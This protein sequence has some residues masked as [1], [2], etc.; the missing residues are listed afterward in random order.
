MPDRVGDSV[1]VKV[2]VGVA[3][4][5]SVTVS[6]D[7]GDSVAV[8]LSDTLPL[9]LQEAE[10]DIVGDTDIEGVTDGVRDRDEP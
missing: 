6:L 5:V 7:E 1:G 3:V 9:G 10:K 4:V 8:T 2:T